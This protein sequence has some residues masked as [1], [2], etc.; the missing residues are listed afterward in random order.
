MRASAFMDT[1]EQAELRATARKFL[2][3]RAPERDVQIWDEEGS[4]PEQLYREIAKLGWYDMVT[5]ADEPVENVAGLLTALCEEVGRASSDLVALL[6]L[7]FSGIRDLARW[8]TPDQRRIY[9]AP[10]LGGDGRFAIGVSE[11]DV[12]SDAASV[13]TRAERTD[14][15]WVV[16]GQ[17][18]YCEGAG[19]PGA[20]MELLV[21][22][23]DSGRKRD[24][25][26]VFLVPADH[27]GVE[28][29]RMPALGRN[30][31]GI[32]EVFL[33]DVQLPDTALLGQPGQGWQILKERLVLE[34]IMIS[35]GFL[36]SVASVLDMTV[37]YANERMQF[38]RSIS[39]YQ[40]VS[41]PLAEMYVRMDAARC[42]VQRAAALFDAGLACE[43][44]STMAKFLTGQIYAEASAL[45]IQIQG[46]YG[47]V[48]D[49]TLPMHHSD[50]IIARVVAGPPSV[51]LDFI[52]RSM[53]LRAG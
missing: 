29:R 25:L 11:P 38:G 15:G 33:H 19:L 26:A 5:D 50:G 23:G 21:K 35:S 4:Y 52:A 40:G 3:R 6:N 46:A 27:P 17:K 48:R 36:G 34:R 20:V 12:G 9:S 44:E 14:G 45:A 16:N 30:I 37:A 41:L 32:Y 18:T 51:Q 42:A 13:T 8:G 7:N 49:H 53:G 28:V 47:Y 2:S 22:V 39:S 31:S 1:E 24:D 43:T 10:V